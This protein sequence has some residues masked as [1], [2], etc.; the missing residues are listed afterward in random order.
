M[1][2]HFSIVPKKAEHDKHQ[3]SPLKVLNQANT[4]VMSFTNF[5]EINP[6]FPYAL[7]QFEDFNIFN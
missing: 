1:E 7:R 4:S 6:N 5:I 2:V 3:I